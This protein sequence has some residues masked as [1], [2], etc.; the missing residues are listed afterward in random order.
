MLDRSFYERSAEEVARDLIGCVLVHRLRSGRILKSVVTETEAYVGE[1]DLASHASKGR[2]PRTSVMYGPPGRAYVYL[3]YGMYELF[4]V[5]TSSV[6]DPQAVLIR[7]GIP[8]SALRK[9][10][11][12]PGKFSLGM[13]ITRAENSSSLI[14]RSFHFERHRKPLRVQKAPRIGVDYAGVW[15]DKKLR[16][17]GFFDD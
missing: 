8:L 14:R 13:G 11:N 6:G 2:T 12:G 10:L 4:N 1:H 5:V 15:R 17:V 9:D 3:I 16:F 7:A